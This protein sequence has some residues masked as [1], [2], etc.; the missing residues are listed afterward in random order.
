MSRYLLEIARCNCSLYWEQSWSYPGQSVLERKIKMKLSSQPGAGSEPALQGG[1]LR[2]LAGM[3]EQKEFLCWLIPARWVFTVHKETRCRMRS[4]LQLA[5]DKSEM[6]PTLSAEPRPGAG[7]GC[8]GNVLLR[9]VC[10]QGWWMRALGGG[11]ERYKCWL[12]SSQ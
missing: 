2:A 11:K 7:A 5:G 6:R 4:T 1:I 10:W 3:E 8:R 9:V 12:L